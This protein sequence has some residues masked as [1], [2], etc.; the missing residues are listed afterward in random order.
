V[1]LA[2][3]ERWTLA[4]IAVLIA[5]AVGA[6]ALA[7]EAAA[8]GEAVTPEAPAPPAPLPKCA[9]ATSFK[10]CKAACRE[11]F[12]PKPRVETRDE[13]LD[14]ERLAVHGWWALGTGAAFLIAGGIIGG[15]TLHLN[16]ELVA[17]CRGGVCPPSRHA[18][19]DTRDR[20]AVTSTVL[21]AA[22]VGASAVGILILAVFSRPPKDGGEQPAAAFAPIAGPQG[23]GAAWT[24]RF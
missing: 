10:T 12:P 3:F 16:G 18:D 23:A 9:E 1:V 7:Q 24:W 13:R 22:G 15:V 14:R 2:R 4:C 21:V 19:L 6:P 8:S 20:L 5:A 11:Q 17:D